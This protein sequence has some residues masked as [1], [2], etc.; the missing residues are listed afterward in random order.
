MHT[1]I[2]AP[3]AVLKGLVAL[4]SGARSESSPPCIELRLGPEGESLPSPPPTRP[5]QA[6]CSDILEFLAPL[7]ENI[8]ALR[9][10]TRGE[11]LYQHSVRA[12]GW[13]WRSRAVTFDEAPRG[14]T[15]TRLLYL[16]FHSLL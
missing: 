16:S 5:T 10:F 15:E 9:G 7:V 12:R 6:F 13:V 4:T 8:E 14:C 1:E 3:T 11:P 2:V